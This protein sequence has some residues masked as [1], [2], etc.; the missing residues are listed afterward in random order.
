M[1]FDRRYARRKRRALNAQG[2]LPRGDVLYLRLELLSWRQEI[3]DYPSINVEGRYLVA[4]CKPAW[5][6]FG[7]VLSIGAL[8]LG[9]LFLY[10][11]A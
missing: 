11:R 4:N 10:L 8:L 2:S 9:A 1:S 5:G 3:R 7:L 6:L